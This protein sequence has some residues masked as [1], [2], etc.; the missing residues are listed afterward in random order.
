M[1]TFFKRFHISFYGLYAIA[2]IAVAAIVRLALLL[3]GW[4]ATNSDEGTM[5]LEAMHIAFR[6]E[7]PIF[8]YGQNYMGM[9]EAYLGAALFRLFGISIFNLRLGMLLIFTLFLVAM[10]LLTSLLYTKKLALVVLALLA[11][12]NSTIIITELLSVGG[13]IETLLFGT[14]LMLLASWLALTH[15]PE[16]ASRQGRWRYFIYG[17]WGFIGGI[18]LYSHMLIAP[19]LAMSGL[20]LLVFCH[21]EIRGWSLL[22]IVVGFIIGAT[23]LIIYNATS[24]FDQNSLAVLW[25]LHRSDGSAPGAPHGLLLLVKEVLGTLLY[26]LPIATNLYPVCPLQSLP[27]FG[28]PVGDTAACTVVQGGWSLGYIFLLITAMFLSARPLW[29][30]WK[31]RRTGS[32]EGTAPALSTIEE[33][34]NTVLE[35]ARLMLVFCAAITILLYVASP[36]AAVRPWSTRYL[37]GVLI[38]LPAVLWPLW[39]GLSAIPVREITSEFARFALAVRSSILISIGT[40]FLL[41]TIATFTLV[42][43]AQAF[44]QQDTTVIHDLSQAGITHMYSDYW[45]C[46]RLIFLTQEHLICGVVDLGISEPGLNRYTPYLS[47]VQADPKAAYVFVANS[48]YD[49]AFQNW[50]RVRHASYQKQIFD[51]YAVYTPTAP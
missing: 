50:M 10:Y 5:G 23:P 51:G 42:P 17:C 6:G 30:R 2:L 22:W 41:G 3:L 46:D 25:Q 9:V 12:G 43:A 1:Q 45:T 44:S 28:S 38:A 14:L 13:V 18:G 8:L 4:P 31:Q 16:S 27:L 32:V 47:E 34:K 15:P 21:R 37:A 40:V 11:V 26:T 33:Q 29:E 20:M 49:Y 35:F 7:H 19:F 39:R 48:D 36:V 24:P